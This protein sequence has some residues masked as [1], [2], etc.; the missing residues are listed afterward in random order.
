M[1]TLLEKM[2]QTRT[3][4]KAD[5]DAL[6]AKTTPSPS[7]AKRA[8]HLIDEIRNLD[9]RIANQAESD[10]REAIAVANKIETGA[11]APLVR[12]SDLSMNAS[13]YGAARVTSEPSTYTERGER[14]GGP[15]FLVDLFRAQIK[16]DSQAHERLAR[17]GRE[18]EAQSRESRA[19]KTGDVPSFVPPNYLVQA[20]AEYAR[21]GRPLVNQLTSLPL[22]PTGMSVTIPKVTTPSAVDTQAT[23]ATTIETQDLADTGIDVDITTVAGY[24]P[25]ARQ[26]LE[27]GV[28]VE[29]MI[30]SDLAAAYAAKVDSIAITAALAQSG[31]SAITYTDG[32]PTA[33][34]LWPK[35]ADAAGR[36]RSSRYTGPTAFV[37][38]PRRWA[39]LQAELSSTTP[40][41]GGAA[42]SVGVNVIATETNPQY[43]GAVAT[44][45]GVPVV[46]DASL[47]TNL[48]AGTNEDVILVGDWRDSVIMED[49]GGVPTQLKFEANAGATLSVNLVAFGYHAVTFARQPASISKI[50]GTGLVAPTL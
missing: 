33:A 43:G 34:E 5:L 16:N 22:P 26:T 27:R 3:A 37:M 4:K 25:V 12:G 29:E 30:F 19:V 24:V 38:H 31:T 32:T 17:H 14:D 42:T 44:M 21:S 20:F 6:L 10:E 11:E 40:L 36:I 1:S 2:R 7:D 9:E 48:G 13:P 50:G 47:P 39:F 45:L 41:V 18:V 15:S 8:D 35:L 23:Q 28:M 46:L 49:N